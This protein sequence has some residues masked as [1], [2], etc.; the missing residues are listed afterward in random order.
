MSV[1]RWFTIFN[2]AWFKNSPSAVRL[3]LKWDRVCVY[4]RHDT[5]V[6]TL[7]VAR[8]LTC[9]HCRLTARRSWV[10]FR[11]VGSEGQVPL[12]PSVLRWAICQAFLCGVYMFSPCS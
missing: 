4:F 5:T 2:N 11:H 1:L 3:L 9:L 7:L 8:W 10:R 12:R 6:I